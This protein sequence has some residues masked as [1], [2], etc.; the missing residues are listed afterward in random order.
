MNLRKNARLTP[1]GRLLMVCRIEEQGWK[2]T[3]AALAA[4]LLSAAH[5]TGWGDCGVVDEAVA[6]RSNT[7]HEQPENG[8]NT[9][10]PYN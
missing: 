3:D 7:E 8:D 1:Q 10:R 4:G 6:V 5:T 2:V 9:K